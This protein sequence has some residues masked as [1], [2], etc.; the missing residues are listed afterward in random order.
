[1]PRKV[2]ASTKQKKTYLQDKRAVK[3]GELDASNLHTVTEKP[4]NPKSRFQK[5]DPREGEDVSRRLQSKFVTVSP[6]YLER[7]RNLAHSDPLIRPIP[8][9]YALFP[10]ELLERDQDKR[11]TCPSR[12]K[13]RYDMTKKEVEKN[14][15]GWYKKWMKSTEE[16]MD[17]WIDG[18]EEEAPVTRSSDGVQDQVEKKPSWPRSVSWFETNLEVWRQLQVSLFLTTFFTNT[19][20]WRVTEVSSIV[21]LLLDSR[22]PPLHCPPSLRSYIQNLKP[23]KE[24]ILV[25]TKSDLVDSEALRGWRTWLKTWWGDEDVQIVAVQSYDVE[26]LQAGKPTSLTSSEADSTDRSRHRPDIPQESLLELVEALQCAHQRLSTPPARI[27]DDPEKA[28]NWKS[29]VRH[30]LDWSLLVPKGAQRVVEKEIKVAG[31]EEQEGPADPLT[32][33]LVG[34]PNVGKS[35]LLNALLGEQRVRASKTPGKVS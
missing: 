4:A 5:S 13:F 9:D 10:V 20:R 22:C 14:E 32:I 29:P 35:S 7:T 27:R 11:L 15:E 23:R 33:G 34:Q 26:M 24:V 17:E 28:G 18:E 8:H 31:A 6:E 3:R 16:I 21:L 12:P 1:M 19:S 30:D 2:K 25:L